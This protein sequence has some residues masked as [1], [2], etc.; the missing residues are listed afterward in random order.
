MGFLRSA[1]IRFLEHLGKKKIEKKY[2]NC[3]ELKYNDPCGYCH[4]NCGMIEF[5]QNIDNVN[6][7]EEFIE[8]I[9]TFH[10]KEK[11]ARAFE[12][13]IKKEYPQYV[14]LLEK[15]ELLM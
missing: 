1:G 10:Y 9:K 6:S 12:F 13:L 7:K 5:A 2:K 11:W 3:V 14:D 8:Y 15:I 4:K